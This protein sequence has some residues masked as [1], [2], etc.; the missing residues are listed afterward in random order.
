MNNYAVRT[1]MFL[2]RYRFAVSF[3]VKALLMIGVAAMSHFRDVDI[4]VGLILLIVVDAITL[5]GIHASMQFVVKTS[6]KNAFMLRFV[7]GPLPDD[8]EQRLRCLI[9]ASFDVL[10]ASGVYTD[11]GFDRLL[12]ES[13]IVREL[14]EI[15]PE[16][17]FVVFMEAKK[18]MKQTK[19]S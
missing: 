19:P 2:A 10:R 1:A 4:A 16:H 6:V 8:E 18:K 5:S 13:D 11:A 12:F 17:P 3:A 7:A 14:A 9:D 15:D